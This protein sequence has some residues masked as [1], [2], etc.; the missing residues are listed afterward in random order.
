M[1]DD[2]NKPDLSGD[3]AIELLRSGVT[4]WNRLREQY[5]TWAPDLQW[6]SLEGYSL[7]GANLES[8]TLSAA[9]FV[10][11]DLSGPDLELRS[12]REPQF[13]GQTVTKERRLDKLLRIRATNPL[14]TSRHDSP[15]RF[16]RQCD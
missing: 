6:A 3:Q 2:K 9:K 11:A 12:A 10:R 8:A 5:S 7:V 15:S 4:R 1:P 16:G 13:P 14:L